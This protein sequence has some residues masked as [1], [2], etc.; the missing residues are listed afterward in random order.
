MKIACSTC[1]KEIPV[2]DINLDRMLAKCRSCNSIMDISPQVGNPAQALFPVMGSG[3]DPSPAPALEVERGGDGLVIVRR[4]NRKHATP[5]LLF[6]GLWIAIVTVVG[7]GILYGTRQT[8]ARTG[9]SGYAGL[10]LTFSPF[11]LIG[12]GTGYGALGLY[13]NRTTIRLLDRELSVSHGPVPWLGGR[14]VDADQIKNLSCRQYIAYIQNRIPQYRFLIEAGRRDGRPVRLVKGIDH[15]GQALELKALLEK[16]LGIE[17]R[18][19][20][21]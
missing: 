14:S 17:G 7:A 16:K 9:P 10:L 1:A 18:P 13:L 6:S 4:W 12:L 19:T 20:E 15:L 11:I 21:S 3:S 2:E 5:M 8:L